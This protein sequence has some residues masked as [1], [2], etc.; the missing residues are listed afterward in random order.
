MGLKASPSGCYGNDFGY[1]YY[2]DVVQT[3]KV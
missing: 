3:R 2:Q 1:A